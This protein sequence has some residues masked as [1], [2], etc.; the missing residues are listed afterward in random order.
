MRPTCMGS[1][2]LSN[3]LVL[4]SASCVF[5]LILASSTSALQAVVGRQVPFAE[6][7]DPSLLSKNPSPE[8]NT[9][10]WS[11]PCSLVKGKR[12]I[13]ARGFR[14]CYNNELP[15][16]EEHR[17]G[18]LPWDE[19]QEPIEESYAG[20]FPIRTWKQ[21][22]YH[23]ETSMYYWFFPA[24]K[25]KVKDPPLLIWLQGGPG[26]SSMIGL[27]FEN[28]PLRVTENG[29]L[30]RQP[31]HWAD[32]YS[33]LFIDQ[34]VGTG[35]SYVTRRS[36]ENDQVV[37]DKASLQ[38]IRES[39][40]SELR[41]NQEKEESFF[42]SNINRDLPYQ[43]EA[44]RLHKQEIL[45][46]KDPL[47]YNGYVK[48]QRGVAQDLLV[49]L[50]QFYERYPE[51]KTRDLYLTGES[52]A[53]KYVPAFAYG[54]LESN[55]GRR[56]QHVNEDPDNQVVAV[57]EQNNIPL[58]GIALGN[59][60][61]DPITQVQIHADHAFYLGLVTKK[62][63][64]RMRFHQELSVQD[65]EMGRFLSSNDNRLEV[66]ETFKNATGGLNWY[67]IRKGSVAN[68]WSRMEAF[69]NLPSIKDALNVFGPRK[70][71]L[72]AQGVPAKEIERIERG[73]N[74]TQYIKDPVVIKT[75][76]G[77]IM[78]SAAWM[79][80]EL[81]END[82]KVLAFQGVFDFRDAVA[83]SQTWLDELSWARQDQFL[84]TERE[85]WI[86]QGQLAG[87]ITRVPGLAKVV[88]LGAGHLAPMDQPT[89][90]LELIRGLVQGFE[91][92]KLEKIGEHRLRQQHV[93]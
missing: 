75:M 90:G 73:R 5:V 18:P 67:D 41:K 85:L 33:V 74:E 23:G 71:Y 48:D 47:F 55:K 70:A 58:K 44:N 50:D 57:N 8:S 46:S 82:I 42:A 1:L 54:I 12:A 65:A 15:I 45:E 32:E 35:Y 93:I 77:D 3:A 26:S 53:G 88:V 31:V 80:S 87:Y 76:A 39:L 79:V 38:K 72:E 64:D 66:F 10:S 86:R 43:S 37:T 61:T 21:N 63:A 78:K 30:A 29:K 2:S 83:G 27:F 16:R 81:L 59:S 84:E 22:G 56:H 17:V 19:G 28:G 60:L 89:A 62:Q 4:V 11:L 52:Y 24:I 20:H 68:D 13:N 25:P 7:A 40:R 9:P 6:H 69:L 51:Q 49:F 91:E 36:D 34:P 14:S 92:I